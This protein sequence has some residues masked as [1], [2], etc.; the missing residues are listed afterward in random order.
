MIIDVIDP[1]LSCRRQSPLPCLKDDSSLNRP[2]SHGAHRF[3][4]EANIDAFSTGYRLDPLAQV[5]APIVDDIADTV[6]AH[7]ACLVVGADTGDDAQTQMAG[8]VDGGEANPARGPSDKH[9]F[10][11]LRSCPLD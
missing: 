4:V 1:F 6:T 2:I 11:V 10:T 9:R 8:E 5:F 7:Q 3:L